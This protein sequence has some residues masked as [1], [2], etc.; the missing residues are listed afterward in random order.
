MIVRLSS[1]G[2]LARISK[3]TDEYVYYKFLGIGGYESK[4]T[5]SFF[6]SVSSSKKYRWEVVT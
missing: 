1:D 5:I 4:E 2:S 6:N 3:I